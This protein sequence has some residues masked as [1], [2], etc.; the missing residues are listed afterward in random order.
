MQEFENLEDLQNTFDKPWKF[1]NLH[2]K[3]KTSL[4]ITQLKTMSRSWDGLKSYCA[5]CEALQQT[6]KEACQRRLKFY[7]VAYESV[8]KV[9]KKL[10]F[11]LRGKECWWSIVAFKHVMIKWTQKV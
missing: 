7:E 8:C 1:C 6:T 10:K 3:H 4:K 9:F 5:T 2:L 11:C